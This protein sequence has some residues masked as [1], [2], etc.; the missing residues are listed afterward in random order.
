MFALF[1]K[2]IGFAGGI[3]S[4]YLRV[5]VI[6]GFVGLTTVAGVMVYQKRAAVSKLDALQLDVDRLQSQIVSKDEELAFQKLAIAMLE[7]TN[8]TLATNAKFL[9]EALAEIKNAPASDDAPISP[10]LLRALRRLDGL[11]PNN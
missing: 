3:F 4:S 6:A 1:T 11:L 7:S 2:V 9:N 10:V 5:I 8:V